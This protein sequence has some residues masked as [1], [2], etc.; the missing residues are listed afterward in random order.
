MYTSG[1]CVGPARETWSAWEARWDIL[2]LQPAWAVLQAA[3]AVARN[4]LPTTRPLETNTTV[5]Q[6]C[7]VLSLYSI[8]ISVSCITQTPPALS[9][10]PSPGPSLFQNGTAEMQAMFLPHFPI[11]QLSVPSPDKSSSPEELCVW[12]WSR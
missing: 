4:M 8:M 12:G 9:S 3:Y 1:R 7:Q 11:Q 6:K 10:Q 2:A 5:Y